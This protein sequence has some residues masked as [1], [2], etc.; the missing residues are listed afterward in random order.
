MACETDTHA[1]SLQGLQ[2][3]ALLSGT[4]ETTR[5]HNVAMADVIQRSGSSPLNP[6]SAFRLIR[7][8]TSAWTDVG[9][10]RSP[11]AFPIT[12]IF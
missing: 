4:R 7:I 3:E 9:K 11:R 6:L 8:R 5:R 1:G 12:V 2:P 10:E